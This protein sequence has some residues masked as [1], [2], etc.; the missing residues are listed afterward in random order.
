MVVDDARSPA[1]L[2]AAARG[3]NAAARLARDDDGAH[4]RAG[5]GVL[6]AARLARH[7]EQ[8]QRIG[9]RA[10]DHG[11]FQRF[12]LGQP[13]GARH[14]AR[15]YGVRADLRRGVER[16]PEAQERPE[17]ERKEDPVA[18][19]DA[20][21]AVDRLPAVEHPLPAFRSVDP[22]QRLAGRGRGLVVARVTLDRLGQHRAP[23]R[24][25]RLI[26]HQLRLGREGQRGQVPRQDERRRVDAGSF[27]LARVEP[28]PAVDV[29]QQAREALPLVRG[30][31]RSRQ[32]LGL[33][34]RPAS[35]VMQ[36]LSRR[37]RRSRRA[38]CGRSAAEWR[39]RPAVGRPGGARRRWSG[40][41]WRFPRRPS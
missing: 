6:A 40:C 7:V 13:L 19:V 14:P 27:E 2:D 15:R 5:Q 12:D 37:R 25:L 22:A 9:R 36:R 21:A 4:G 3:R 1:A 34:C 29:A 11:G 20:G 18:A 35:A 10:A 26:G 28:V 8:P 33:R 39:P 24:R 17:R 31:R 38:A 32:A 41:R 16:R 30:E 23:G